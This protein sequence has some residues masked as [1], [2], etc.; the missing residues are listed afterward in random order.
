M[1]SAR[2]VDP[3][4]F[5]GSVFALRTEAHR[6]PPEPARDSHNPFLWTPSLPVSRRTCSRPR[7]RS[8]S[9]SWSRSLC[10]SACWMP[11]SE[12]G[13]RC[14]HRDD[15]GGEREPH[16][17]AVSERRAADAPTEL[18]LPPHETRPAGHGAMALGTLWSTAR[19]WSRPG[20]RSRSMR[21]TTSR[22]PSA[23]SAGSGCLG[24]HGLRRDGQREN[25]SHGVARLCDTRPTDR[26]I[27]YDT[28]ATRGSV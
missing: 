25:L 7:R 6:V 16:A 13:A 11:R 20:A 23:G 9:W 4:E 21:R 22:R 12:D 8:C 10:S 27:P 14:S 19:G 18:L 28:F 1:R 15:D 26:P 5:C 2:Q 3:G 17:H 24:G